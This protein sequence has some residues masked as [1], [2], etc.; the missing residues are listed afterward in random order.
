MNHE[1][2]WRMAVCHRFSVSQMLSERRASVR[3]WRCRCGL[4]QQG[5]RVGRCRLLSG[6]ARAVNERRLLLG[7]GDISSV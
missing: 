2:A 3:L 1:H 7:T 4:P 5:A 6:Q